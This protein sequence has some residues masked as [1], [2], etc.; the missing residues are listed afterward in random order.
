MQGINRRTDR[1][2]WR[3]VSNGFDEPSHHCS[4]N[5]QC[6]FGK[7]VHIL[8]GCE[9]VDCPVTMLYRNFSKLCILVRK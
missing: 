2:R 8:H 1:R 7:R 6:R 5:S 4:E 3:A 9:P